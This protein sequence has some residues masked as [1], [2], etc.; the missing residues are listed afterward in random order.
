MLGKTIMPRTKSE[1]IAAIQ[2]APFRSVEVFEGDRLG[3]LPAAD[4]LRR[5]GAT[6]I[7]LS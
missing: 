3:G 1:L 2:R 4:R 7:V 6:V 5:S